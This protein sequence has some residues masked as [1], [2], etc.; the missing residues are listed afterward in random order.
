[1]I[2]LLFVLFC[3]VFCYE[4]S[5]SFFRYDLKLMNCCLFAL[6]SFIGPCVCCLLGAYNLKVCLNTC[7]LRRPFPLDISLGD[8]R[9]FEYSVVNGNCDSWSSTVV[10]WCINIRCHSI[11][12]VGMLNHGYVGH[13]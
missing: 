2:L 3:F 1:M 6:Y 4:L 8:L 5:I 12:E 11:P 13:S 9:E 10:R 7:S